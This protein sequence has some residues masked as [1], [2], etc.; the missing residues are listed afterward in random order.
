MLDKKF[1][2]EQ[3]QMTMLEWTLLVRCESFCNWEEKR[4]KSELFLRMADP[5]TWA[6]E[7]C[8]QWLLLGIKTLVLCC[9]DSASSCYCSTWMD[10]T[11]QADQ[12]CLGYHVS[13]QPRWVLGL[14]TYLE[15]LDDC[16]LAGQLDLLWSF[17]CLKSTHVYLGGTVH[18]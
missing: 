9:M 17:V 18:F 12:G 15:G 6:P 7:C 2:D 10:R 5:S 13:L 8:L 14:L 16:S 3:F 4:C 11:P 1:P